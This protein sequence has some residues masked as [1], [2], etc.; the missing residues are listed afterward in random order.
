MRKMY[1]LLSVTF[2]II[3]A[4]ST[5]QAQGIRVTLDKSSGCA[6]LTINFT[7]H[8]HENMDTTGMKFTWYF[9]DT[10][11]SGYNCT[12]T[13]TK[14]GH[15]YDMR[16]CNGNGCSMLPEFDIWGIPDK[17]STSTG[18]NACPGEQVNMWANVN[19]VDWMKWDFGD[20]KNNQSC[21]TCTYTSHSYSTIGNYTVKL[22]MGVSACGIS[23]TIEQVMTINNTA[24]PSIQ[25]LGTNGNRFCPGD[26]IQFNMQNPDIYD[27]VRWNFG[28]G[29]FSNDRIPSHAFATMG[30]KMIILTV[31]NKCGNSTSDTTYVQIYNNI[32]V[33]KGFFWNSYGDMCP[34]NQVTFYP[35]G[36]GNQYSWDFGDG[37]TSHEKNPAHFFNDTGTYKVKFKIS[38]NCGFS[39]SIDRDVLIKYNPT[40]WKPNAQIAFE[41]T[42]GNTTSKKVCPNEEVFFSNWSGGEGISYKWN[43]GDGDS[44]TTKTASHIWKS[45]GTYNVIM[46][47]RNNCLANGKDT[48]QVIVDATTLPTANMQVLQSEICPGEFMYF[49]PN[50]NSNNLINKYSFV[51]GDGKSEMNLS[52]PNDTTIGVFTHKYEIA[53]SY[54]YTISATNIC[55]NTAVVLKDTVLVASNIAKPYYLAFNTASKMED[56]TFANYPDWKTKKNA[57][58]FKLT[59]PATWSDWKEGYETTYGLAFYTEPPTKDS[60]AAAFSRY[61]WPDTAIAYIPTTPVHDSIYVIAVW[62]CDGVFQNGNAN[63]FG[64]YNKGIH[65]VSSGS[66]SI[67]FP[68]IIMQTEDWDGSCDDESSCPGDTVGFF[69]MGG[70]SY[71]W[72]FGDGSAEVS[73][74]TVKHIYTSDKDSTYD[75]FVMITTGCGKTDTIHSPAKVGTYRKPN[76]YIQTN[77]DQFC[78]GDTVYFNDEDHGGGPVNVK[79]EKYLWNFGD[80]KTSTDE[81]PVHIFEQPGKYNI[82]LT[83]SNN[84]GDTTVTREIY[85]DGPKIQ[86]TSPVIVK[87]GEIVPFS[88]QTIN[89][90]SYEWTFGNDSVSNKREPSVKYLNF[91]QYSVTLKAANARGCK[92]TLTK[93]NYMTV[94]KTPVITNVVVTNVSC[95]GKKDGA[96]DITVA[97]GEPPFSYTWS[98]GKFMQDI[99]GLD[100]GAYSVTIKDKNNTTIIGNY[101]ITQPG[102]LNIPPLVKLNESCL[103]K[104]NGS[105]TANPAGGTAPYTYQWSNGGTTQS[106]TNLTHLRYSVTVTDAKKCIATASDTVI[107]AKNNLITWA[108][109]IAANPACGAS[110]GQLRVD[111]VA[112]GPYSYNWNSSPVQTTQ[113]TAANLPARAYKVIVTDNPSGCKDSAMVS[114]SNSGT[115]LNTWIDQWKDVSCFGKNDANLRVNQSGGTGSYTYQWSNGQTSQTATN[116]PAG[117]WNVVVTDGANCKGVQSGLLFSPKPMSLAFITKPESCPG[118]YDGSALAVVSGGVANPN[119]WNRRYQWSNMWD[120][121]E[122]INIGAGTYSVTVTDNN[123]PGCTI[124]GN[125]NVSALPNVNVTA[126]IYNAQVRDAKDGAINAVVSNGMAPYSYEWTWAGG[127]SNSQDIEGIKAGDYTLTVTDSKNCK[128]TS[129][130]TVTQ[131]AMLTTTKIVANRTFPMCWGEEAELDA[132]TGYVKYLWTANNSGF[133]SQTTQKITVDTAMRVY[134]KAFTNTTYGIDS[135]DVKVNYPYA[136]EAICMVTVDSVTGKNKLIWEK[137]H[138]MNTSAYNVYKIVGATN[139]LIGTIPFGNLTVFNDLTSNPEKN[140]DRYVITTVDSCGHESGKS[141]YHETMLLGASKGTSVNE[142]VLDWNKYIDESG[143][144]VP[145]W[146]YIYKGPDKGNLTLID[147]VSGLLPTRYNDQVF[148]GTSAFYL[149][150]IRK[151]QICDPADLLKA[152]SGPYSQSLS[153][154]AEFKT[155]TDPEGMGASANSI[156]SAYPN[157]FEDKFDISF[158]LENAGDVA[159]ELSTETGAKA[160]SIMLKDQSAGKHTVTINAE[161]FNMTKGMYLVK[162]VTNGKT[163]V[164]K[165]F[166]NK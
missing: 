113:V 96:I 81:K 84:C 101:N 153:N 50:E 146:Y 162:V 32:G 42:D 55:G 139:T 7:N 135:M 11:I 116:L 133:V 35:N 20:G 138:N 107:A 111:V 37:E 88:N 18:F 6:P 128:K 26:Q 142:A 21:N 161:K 10:T 131:P 156:V 121:A 58:D 24:K 51:Y 66:L 91:G 159:I 163:S 112:G 83:V 12:R 166:C 164:L 154:L 137:T 77:N 65:P 61:Q 106:I 54:I 145:D 152:E 123:N 155:N 4:I 23:D 130:F 125:V 148:N 60:K 17:I 80:G 104:G 90:V 93:P 1:R 115:T 46:T 126:N 34:G 25:N 31:W 47:A 15:Y 94:L 134:V 117:N 140:V 75:A 68:G 99:S 136:D 92:A 109:S 102:P 150:S 76:V 9:P 48:L 119:E 89:A 70:L 79:N 69:A 122:N 13:F 63:A 36:T 43:F 53:G 27:S 56:P 52:K 44:L 127:N 151:P 124:T 57:S 8:S 29:S 2:A 67:P 105:L 19:K 62:M 41:N 30:G 86:F 40:G 118:A 14:A 82:N 71:K 87:Q 120:Q 85:I 74:Q 28:D 38:N 98:N 72:N 141:P 143:S 73:G 147:S 158:I 97:G 108:G 33:D 160:G 95:N 49:I 3:I 103:D 5:S 45:S 78:V 157:P 59:I 16:L 39:D 144:W 114:L 110:T 100:P 129:T 149:I 132:N 64:M 22:A 165:V